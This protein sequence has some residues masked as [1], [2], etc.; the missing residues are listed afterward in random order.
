MRRADLQDDMEPIGM[1]NMAK[2][3]APTTVVPAAMAFPT[4]AKSMRQTMCKDLSF[5][6]AELNVTQIDRRKVANYHQVGHC[7]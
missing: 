5:V 7:Q 6:L 3:R 2:N 4:A 1:R